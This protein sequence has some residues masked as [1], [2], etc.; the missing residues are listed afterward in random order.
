MSAQ[1][2]IAVAHASGSLPRVLVGDARLQA[3]EA[4]RALTAVAVEPGESVAPSVDEAVLAWVKRDPSLFVE[5]IPEA[6]PF[7]LQGAGSWSTH[8]T[9]WGTWAHKLATI[10][11]FRS[12]KALFDVGVHPDDGVVFARR[13]VW[14]P[15]WNSQPEHLAAV[16]AYG[17]NPDVIE[18]QEKP[19]G[20][21][22][23]PNCSVL[24]EC[25]AR[26][27]RTSGAVWRKR[28]WDKSISSAVV[29]SENPERVEAMRVAIECVQL[30]LR[31]GA[32]RM[33]PSQQ[34]VLW[35]DGGVMAPK[36]EGET[37]IGMLVDGLDNLEGYPRDRDL[38][39]QL[40]EE[41]R[42]AGADI[43]SSSGSR[44]LP[45]VV[46]AVRNKDI[47]TFRLLL[48]LGASTRDNDFVRESGSGSG[49]YLEAILSIA[50]EAE[51]AGGV[52]FRAQVVEAIM[53]QAAMR[54]KAP[55]AAPA[56]RRI[57]RAS[58]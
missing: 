57:A 51:K 17:A 49:M 37:A 36:N 25:L 34:E 26:V 14:Q 53:Q 29:A 40:C 39:E 7:G 58:V 56:A 6:N 44:Q 9:W 32:R 1:A 5:S 18:C 48:S 52:E 30:L 33:E 50:D 21:R 2:V 41:L 35:D 11:C 23:D 47:R 22:A 24:R 19:G 42:A 45:P 8:R 10:G 38:L 55:E 16:L 3:H 13:V 46:K 12:T 28:E 43:D 31:A 27:S 15:N 4:I 20:F 54:T